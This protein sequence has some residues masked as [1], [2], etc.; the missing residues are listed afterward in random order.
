MTAARAAVI[1]ELARTG[2]M[3]VLD[4]GVLPAAAMPAM[5]RRLRR[6]GVRV[7]QLRMKSAADRDLVRIARAVRA[8]AR[9]V[10]LVINDRCDL[11]V[12]AGADGVHLGQDD[13]PVAVARRLLGLRKFVGLSAGSPAEVRRAL[14]A[15]PDAISLGPFF[16][17]GTKHDAGAPL[18]PGGFRRLR[19]SIPGGRLVLAIGGITPDNGAV[20]LDCGARAVA[21]ARGLTGARHP[22]RAARRLLGVIRRARRHNSRTTEG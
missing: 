11:A 15:R 3:A 1:R 22:E 17:T 8:A 16:N 12:A 6:A 7:F 9:G 10:R 4:D 2:I 21:V 14:S 18:G 19:S 20:P 5:A 13:L